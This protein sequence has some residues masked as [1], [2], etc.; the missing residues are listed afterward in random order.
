[1]S[2]H[3][4]A[5]GPP[6]VNGFRDVIAWRDS[7]RAAGSAPSTVRARLAA[8]SSWF[9]FLR[10]QA[11]PDGAR[12]VP[13]NPA[14]DVR[15]GRVDPY[16]HALQLELAELKSI[17]RCADPR[18]RAW[19]LVHVLTGRRRAEV[20]RL[21]PADLERRGATWWYRYRGKGRAESRWRELPGAAVEAVLAWRPDLED[22]DSAAD[23]GRQVWG[24]SESTL[25]RH[26]KRAAQS[27][28]VDARRAHVHALRHLAAKLR[29]D[30]QADIREIQEFLDHASPSTTVLY[31]QALEERRDT[32]AD[33]IARHLLDP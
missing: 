22:P 17:M 19:L 30:A 32:R 21:R 3:Q 1:V 27:A 9:S 20:A 23:P 11:T 15:A 12:L 5:G 29:R 25:V 13:D 10:R 16:G 2:F 28:G 24:C 7:L 8:V 4:A 6:S 33:S 14:E 31:L 18:L 26:L